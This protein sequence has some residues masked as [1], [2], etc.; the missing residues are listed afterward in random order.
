M[1]FRTINLRKDIR[2]L[3]EEYF[4]QY[5]THNMDVYD[6]GCGSKPFQNI[7]TGKVKNYIGVDIEDGFYDTRHIDLLG[8][9]YNVP[10]KAN[11]ADAVISSQV[12][13]HLEKPGSAIKETARILREGGLFF[14]SIPF[15]YPLHAEPHDFIRF[16]EFSIKKLLKAEK[17]EIL[18]LKK[19]GGFWYM[20]GQF[21]GIYLQTFDK[22]FLKRIKIIH[23]L[24]QFIR[25]LFYISHLIEGFILMIIK[26]SPEKLRS[27]W[28]VGYVLVAK[29][30]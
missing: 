12:L 15:L 16:T 30:M 1:L 3:L 28:A 13:E 2:S 26:K 23:M 9:A 20:A 11:S 7:L 17:F 21:L 27:K 6:V 4:N 10:I 5:L 29:K 24:I 22:G 8:T 18:E 25:W 19:V 14:L